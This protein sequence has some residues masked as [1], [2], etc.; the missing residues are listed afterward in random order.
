MEKKLNILVDRYEKGLLNTPNIQVTNMIV[1]DEVLNFPDYTTS[2]DD[3][4]TMNMSF[5]RC[6]VKNSQLKRIKISNANFESGFFTG[7]TLENCTFESTNF[8]ELECEKCVF[9]NCSFIDCWFVDSYISE[10]I[11]SN[12]KFEK[13]SLE[14]AEFHSCEFIDCIFSDIILIFT[15]VYDSKF[16]KFEKF[17]QFEGQTFLVDILSPEN[18]IT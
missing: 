18:G 12:C 1:F 16:S 3:S 7:S 6:L 9:K 8:Q 4:L 2:D 13:G 11:F 10:T 15:T 14:S 5:C 17:I